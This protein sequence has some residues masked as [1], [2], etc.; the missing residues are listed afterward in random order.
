MS[1]HSR[2]TPECDQHLFDATDEDTGVTAIEAVPID[3]ARRLE[4]QRDECVEAL[5]YALWQH[6]G[7]GSPMHNHW[8]AKSQTTLARIWETKP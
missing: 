7:G 5:E 1:T 4:Q 8:T 3:V 6:N 2:P